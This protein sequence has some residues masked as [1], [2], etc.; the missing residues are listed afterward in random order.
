MPFKTLEDYDKAIAKSD[1]RLKDLEDRYNKSQKCKT[2]AEQNRVIAITNRLKNDNYPVTIET[3]DYSLACTY[4]H[5]GNKIYHI[6]SYNNTTSEDDN[7]EILKRFIQLLTACHNF[8]TT[9]KHNKRWSIPQFFSLNAT[10]SHILISEDTGCNDYDTNGRKHAIT[11]NYNLNT[12]VY[13]ITLI[14]KTETKS[15]SLFD[16]HYPLTKEINLSISSLYNNDTLIL[17]HETTHPTRLKTL[18]T[19]LRAIC[20][21]A[22]PLT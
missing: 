8:I 16:N 2:K 6:S 9:S 3:S 11:I 19:D 21:E 20:K 1:A 4:L 5:L 17:S 7:Y 15:Q 12:N 14:T 13:S 18:T 22:T 10:N